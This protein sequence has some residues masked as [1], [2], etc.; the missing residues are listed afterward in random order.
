MNGCK[1]PGRRSFL[2]QLGA[3]TAWSALTMTGQMP[4]MAR[5][6]AAENYSGIDDYRSLVCVFLSGGIDT[7]NAFVPY[8]N[9]DNYAS[10]R[11]ALAISRNQLLPDSSGALGFHPS[12]AP[13]RTLYNEGKLAIAAN[14]GNLFEPLTASEVFDYFGEDVSPKSIPRELFSHS[15][16][17]D[18]VQIN[19][20]RRP[21]SEAPGWG[22]LMAD[23]LIEAS[24]DLSFPLSYTVAGNN[25][26]QT[27][28]TSRPFSVR[29]GRDIPV[30]EHFDDDTWP[31]WEPA[32]SAAWTQILERSYTHPLEAQ[33]AK[34]ML[35]TKQRSDLLRSELEAAPPF[36]TPFNEDNRLENQLRSVA[37]L[38]SIRQ[39]VGLRRQLFFVELGNW[40]THSN[41]L[42][43]H[44]EQLTDLANGLFSFQR[45]IDELGL[46]DSVTTFTISEFNRTLTINGDGTDHA[47]AGEQLVMG[48][49]VDGGKVHGQPIDYQSTG[50]GQ[51]WGDTLFGAK[52]V[53]SGRFIPEYSMDQYGAT[54]AKWM[55]IKGTDLATIFPNLK[56]FAQKDLGFMRGV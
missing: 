54:L 27:G 56:N 10:L 49:A 28:Q 30:F 40:D 33:V 13:L 31:R 43:R 29:P 48:G 39:R 42:E 37:K 15:H 41:H 25:L 52:D 55:G 47:W 3:T 1:Q 51:H 20:A 9:Y 18:L 36:N 5:A 6:L 38:I 50:I 22:G 35:G 45:T 26:W 23:R 8:A 24:T 4:L 16:Q 53:G 32:R 2:R 21:G 19:A 11:Q 34:A 44:G 14:L 17:S 46:S 7:H 12:L